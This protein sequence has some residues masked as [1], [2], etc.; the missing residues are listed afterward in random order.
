MIGRNH[1]EGMIKKVIAVGEEAR[2]KL[3]RGVIKI[4]QMVGS[5][6]GPNGKNAIIYKKYSSPLVTND[7]VTIARHIVLD[8]EVEDLGAQTI[9]EVA[10]KTNDQ[11]GDGTTTSVVIAVNLIQDCFDK[12]KDSATALGG[13]VMQMFQQIQD[14]KRKAVELLKAQA[15][16]VEDNLEKIISTSLENKEYGKIVSDMIT[17]IGK[18]GY[19]SVEDNWATQYGITA[20]TIL[21]MKFYGT[22]VTPYMMTTNKKEAIIEDCPILVVNGELEEIGSLAKNIMEVLKQQGKTKLVIFAPSYTRQLIAALANVAIGFHEGKQMQILAVKCPTQTIEELKDIAAF[23]KADVIDRSTGMMLK[24]VKVDNLGGAKK[25]VVNQDDVIITGG[26]GDVS[27][28]VAD[29]QAQV[30]LEKDQMF[31]EKLK[32]RISSLNAGIGIIRVGAMTQTERDYWKLKIEDAKNAGKAALEEGTVKGGGLALKEVAEALG[33]KDILYK[34][35][36]APYE[37][38]QENSGGNYEIGEDILD[39]VKVTR[40]ALE[41]ACSAASVFITTETAITEHRKTLVEELEKALVPRNDTDDFRDDENQ[42]QGA[43]RIVS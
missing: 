3:L 29:L 21:G 25:I 11:A 34:A 37:K 23:V 9:V 43:G 18:D 26:N 36:I 41:N 12:L 38:I 35:L 42:D 8:D 1:Q 33:D 4:G 20:E 32:R 24:N 19:I 27:A 30:E 22:Y 15:K 10:M 2:E 6:L 39:P 14:S 5:T 13:S 17:Q 31:K 7:G 16:P 28:R 40:L